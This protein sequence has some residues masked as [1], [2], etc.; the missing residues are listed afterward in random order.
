VLHPESLS[1]SPSGAA[2]RIVVSDPQRALLIV[3][4]MLYPEP[5]PQAGVHPSASVAPGAEIASDA[6][7]GPHAVIAAGARVGARARIGAGVV[8]A[9]GTQVGEE[10]IIEPNAVLYRGTRVGRRC[11]VK[12]GAIL[13]S[14][15]FGFRSSAKGHARVPHVGGCVIEDE[16][17]IGACCTIDRGTLDDTVIGSGTKLDNLIHVG[18]NVRM[19]ARC[20]LMAGTVIGGSTTINDDV[21][22]SGNCTLRDHLT[23]GRRARIGAC[24]VV[25]IDVPAASE[26]SGY[27]ARPHRETLRAQAAMTRL[28]PI[29]TRLEHLASAGENDDHA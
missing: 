1:T 4:P 19:G 20:L 9:D 10:S 28:S 15:G 27:P 22:I 2:A 29:V 14:A 21:I 18:H 25:T 3:L 13:G 23:I 8:M 16:A 17:E 5:A 11:L 26:Y 24:S 12:A 6:T 7:V